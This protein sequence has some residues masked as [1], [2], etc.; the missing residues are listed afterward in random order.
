MTTGSDFSPWPPTLKPLIVLQ[1]LLSLGIL[2]FA[3]LH[4]LL[5]VAAAHS[6]ATDTATGVPMMNLIAVAAVRFPCLRLALLCSKP[7]IPS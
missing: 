4:Q 6:T 2:L 7:D 1:L 5:P 3:T